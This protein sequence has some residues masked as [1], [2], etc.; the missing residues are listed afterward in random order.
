MST[1][2]PDSSIIPPDQPVARFSPDMESCFEILHRRVTQRST[3]PDS[4]ASIILGVRQIQVL[5]YQMRDHLEVDDGISAGVV[6]ALPSIELGPLLRMLTA[7][8]NDPEVGQREY[9][10]RNDPG[11]WRHRSCRSCQPLQGLERLLAAI[12]ILGL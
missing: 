1:K 9:E 7:W 5:Y 2:A 4:A 11:S 3:V 8:S 12:Q 10:R 6:D